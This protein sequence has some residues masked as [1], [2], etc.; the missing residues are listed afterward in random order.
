[1]AAARHAARAAGASPRHAR[2]L[3]EAA[4]S[5]SSNGSSMSSAA[6]TAGSAST[7]AAAHSAGVEAALRGV[8]LGPAL[9]P[10]NIADQVRQQCAHNIFHISPI[11][12]NGKK[13]PLYPSRNWSTAKKRSFNSQC[14]HVARIKHVARPKPKDVSKPRTLEFGN[15]FGHNIPMREKQ[16][17]YTNR[18]IGKPTTRPN[19]VPLGLYNTNA[20]TKKGKQTRNAYAAR[21]ARLSNPLGYVGFR[22]GGSR[23]NRTQK[24]K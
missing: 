8:A 3:A 11:T 5:V 13:N 15:F 18:R 19:L 9:S 21:K 16:K 23:S 4:G 20:Q 2:S 1:M 12:K 6:G 7:A 17:R 10:S 14:D 24:R 22:Y